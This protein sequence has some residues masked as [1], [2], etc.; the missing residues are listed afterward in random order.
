MHL[1]AKSYNRSEDIVLICLLIVYAH[2]FLEYFVTP[3]KYELKYFKPKRD[4]HLLPITLAKLWDWFCTMTQ[5]AC[6]E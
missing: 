5:R 6:E 1:F 3:N 4:F 2:G